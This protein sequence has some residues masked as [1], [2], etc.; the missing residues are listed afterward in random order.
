MDIH[1]NYIVSAIISSSVITSQKIVRSLEKS[2]KQRITLFGKNKLIIHTDRGTQFSSKA[3]NTFATRYNEYFCPSMAREN[4]PT[5]NSV[6]ERFMRTF[7]EHKIHET[8]IEEK[9]SNNILIEPNF[10]SYRSVLNEYIRSLNG[11]PNKKSKTSPQGHYRDVLAASR[12]M[13]DPKY[14]QAR[15]VYLG[16]DFRINEV[17]KFKAENIKVIAILKDIAAR[18]AEL[19]EKT[20]F[21]NFEDNI[22]LQIID[23][24]LNEIYEIISNNPQTT[25]QYVEEIIEPV[26]KSLNQLHNKVDQLLSKD[27]KHREILPLRDPINSDLFPIFLANAGSK[28]VRQKDLKRAELRLAYTLLYFTDLRINEIRMITEKQ[29]LDAILSAQFNAIHYKNRQAHYH[30]LS[31]TA[32]KSL[33]QLALERTIIFQKYGYKYLFGKH[34]P[35]HQKS[36]I[37]LINIDLNNTCKIWDIPYNIKSHSFRINMISNLLKITTVQHA[38]QIIGHNDIQS[39]MNYQR[40]ALS[41]F[42]NSP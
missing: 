10:R 39:T 9:L 32:L 22:V 14:T 41:N 11:K 27:K 4:T 24:R 8:T 38:A 16:E 34:K 36:L 19:V 28:A 15:S 30:V 3:Y 40:Y 2:I 12:L 35:I 1:T 42:R 17:E 21:D 33:K 37:R 31:K 13:R 7:K 18:K 26:E 23:N 6:A 25:R 5:D 29:I 20:P